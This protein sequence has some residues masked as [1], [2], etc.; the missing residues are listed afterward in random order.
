MA[1]AAEYRTGQIKAQI[2][3]I[4]ELVVD[5]I[6]EEIQKEHIAGNMHQAAVQKGVA[7]KL[8]QL[9]PN[10]GEHKMLHPGPKFQITC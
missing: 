5:I 1:Y 7:Y 8:P 10:T 3:D 9:R 4:T 2:P 6:T